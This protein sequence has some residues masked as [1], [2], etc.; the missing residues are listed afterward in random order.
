[1]PVK[2]IQVQT[3]RAETTKENG[4]TVTAVP[5]I[6]NCENATH[7]SLYTRDESGQATWVKDFAIRRKCPEDTYYKALAE[8][9]KL[10]MTHQVPIEPIF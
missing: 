8:A 2:S 7:W 10:S 4:T 9:A 1:M 6:D 3:T 5:L